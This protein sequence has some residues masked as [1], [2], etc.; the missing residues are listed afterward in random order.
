MLRSPRF[1]CTKY[2][3]H[4][5][6]GR[7][8]R[9]DSP[10]TSLH[11]GPSTATTVGA[12]QHDLEAEILIRKVLEIQVLQESEGQS[13]YPWK[14]TKYGNVETLRGSFP[15]RHGELQLVQTAVLW[16]SCLDEKTKVLN[17]KMKCIVETIQSCR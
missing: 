13:E 1:L 7:P 15:T 6:P 5:H 11:P 8:S 4:Y 2:S 9:T 3:S 17:V 14:L 16:L 12:S 10:D